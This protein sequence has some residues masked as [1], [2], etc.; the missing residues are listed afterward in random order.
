MC[1]LNGESLECLFT[2]NDIVSMI[3]G[4]VHILFRE[5]HPT[6]FAK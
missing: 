3:H 2:S 5:I 4:R 6:T 1:F